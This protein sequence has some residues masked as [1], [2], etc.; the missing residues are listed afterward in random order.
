M[1]KYCFRSQ[2]KT[3]MTSITVLGMSIVVQFMT[4][5]LFSTTTLLEKIFTSNYKQSKYFFFKNKLTN[6][7]EY[8]FQVLLHY[9]NEKMS[10]TGPRLFPHN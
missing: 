8:F 6:S 10:L 4:N 3:I 1:A 9:C 2:K 5:G 7:N